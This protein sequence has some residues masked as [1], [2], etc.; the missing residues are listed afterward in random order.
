MPCL[1]GALGFKGF[2]TA[3]TCCSTAYVIKNHYLAFAKQASGVSKLYLLLSVTG[4]C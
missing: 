4:F 2:I 1:Y 3:L